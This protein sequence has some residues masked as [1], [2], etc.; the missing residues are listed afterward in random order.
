MR[1]NLFTFV[2]VPA[3]LVALMT[4]MLARPQVIEN[5]VAAIFMSAALMIGILAFAIRACIDD[6][7]TEPKSDLTPAEYQKNVGYGMKTRD[8]RRAN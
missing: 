7:G 5:H 6:L 8:V 4:F 2:F 3:S 1:R